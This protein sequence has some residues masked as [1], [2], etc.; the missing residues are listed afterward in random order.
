VCV[1]TDFVH[2]TIP[3]ALNSNCVI[4]K[5]NEIVMS[6]ISVV[7]SYVYGAKSKQNVSTVLNIN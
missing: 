1:R 6:S 7:I 5:N 3:A 4:Q 2:L